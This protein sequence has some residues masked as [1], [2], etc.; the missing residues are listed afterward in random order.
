MGSPAHAIRPTCS[1]M[2]S[3]N[4]RHPTALG[5]ADPGRPTESTRARRRHPVTLVWSAPGWSPFLLT[6][7]TE[8]ARVGAN[9]TLG[10]SWT[11]GQLWWRSHDRLARDAQRIVL[12]AAVRTLQTCICCGADRSWREPTTRLPTAVINTVAGAVRLRLCS[13]CR[14][15]AVDAA[16][17]LVEMEAADGAAGECR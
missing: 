10:V 5:A 7:V 14:L 15:R 16:R 12:G 11:T 1:E 9:V 3:T 6:A 4:A 2:T 17:L 13:G 8:L